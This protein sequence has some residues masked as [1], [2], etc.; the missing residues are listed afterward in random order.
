MFDYIISG[1]CYANRN[2]RHYVIPYIKNDVIY[3]MG[4]EI[5]KVLKMSQGI[6]S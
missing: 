2:I 6:H 3:E 4:M 1:I 5:F